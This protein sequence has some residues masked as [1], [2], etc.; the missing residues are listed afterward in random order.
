MGGPEFGAPIELGIYGETEK[1]VTQAAKKIESYIRSNISG[2]TNIFSTRAYPS[3]EW[4]VQVDNQNIAQL[5]VNVFDVGALVQMLT[6]GF[7]VG[8]FNP[9]DARDEIDIR[10]R[11]EPE[12]RTITGTITKVQTKNGLVPVSSF[13]SVRFKAIQ[14]EC[15]S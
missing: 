6:S 13:I 4:S 9:D 14:R 7:K 12:Y 11:F 15:Y 8:E 3:V 10:A 5:G 1:E 2:L